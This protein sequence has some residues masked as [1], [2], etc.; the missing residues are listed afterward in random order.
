MASVGPLVAGYALKHRVVVGTAFGAVCAMVMLSSAFA[1]ERLTVY[2]IGFIMRFPSDLQRLLSRLFSRSS[3]ESM[4]FRNSPQLAQL[5]QSLIEGI[6]NNA[7]ISS[8]LQKA[9]ILAVLMKEKKMRQ[10]TDAEITGYSAGGPPLPDYRKCRTGI[11]AHFASFTVKGKK[12]FDP[13][14][15]ESEIG[16]EE[17]S[18]SRMPI[19]FPASVIESHVSSGEGVRFTLPSVPLEP[20]VNRILADGVHCFSACFVV[21]SGELDSVL[22]AIRTKILDFAIA[23]ADDLDGVA[24]AA[25]RNT[26][27]HHSAAVSTVNVELKDI[28]NMTSR[29]T[30]ISPTGST[31]SNVVVDSTVVASP[32]ATGSQRVSKGGAGKTDSLQPE[33]ELLFRQEIKDVLHLL[34]DRYEDIDEALQQGLSEVLSEMRKLSV[35]GKTLSELED[36]LGD[37]W[38]KS[39]VAGMK[40]G[41]PQEVLDVLSGKSFLSLL[42][43]RIIKTSADE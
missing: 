26:H 34:V 19:H 31:L 35:Q 39:T 4:T 11:H 36:M 23:A 28:G 42:A 24:S 40:T 10:W 29:T 30:T 2:P 1:P 22:A 43:K 15:I 38:A 37:L 18:L 5:Q 7:P 12:V 3:Q 21:S 14:V 6:I 9:K 13:A 8:V 20:F 17:G 33:D 16:L 32:L 41:V 27:L 25:A